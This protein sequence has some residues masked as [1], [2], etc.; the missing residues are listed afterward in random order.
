MNSQSH[1]L[2]ARRAAHNS[3]KR[4]KEDSFNSRKENVN[5]QIQTRTLKPAHVEKPLKQLLAH[6]ESFAH[7]RRPSLKAK[8]KP[9]HSHK[10]V[11]TELNSN[12]EKQAVT[13]AVPGEKGT[14]I[15]R[16]SA[17]AFRDYGE[18]IE[19]Y[20][21]SLESACHT[22]E[23]LN[24]HE[25]TA[26]LR[27]KMVD[28]MIEV[29]TNFKCNDQAFFMAVSLMDRYL[30]SKGERKLI[31]ELHVIGVTAM[32]LASKYEDILPLRME[33]MVK[34]IAHSKLSG[35]TIRKYEH[36]MLSTLNYFLQVPTVLEFMTRYIRGLEKQFRREKE[37]IQKMSLYL[38]KL[39]AHDYDFCGLAASK[40]AISSIYVALKI[41]EQLLKRE[42]TSREIV[43]QMA[44]VSGY[45]EEE[46]T[47]CAQKI[48]LDA[49][50]FDSL[51]PGLINLKRTHF[52]KL[53]EYIPKCTYLSS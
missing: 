27:A 33:I 21:K 34:K 24:R 12:G 5:L 9:E 52:T 11:L 43:Q 32:F 13:K 8:P 48:L 28:W 38:L 39:S 18:E 16:Q 41:G 3:F 35:E 31:C 45:S 20:E 6:N 37:L 10:G 17:N 36:D 30:K 50:N 23:C 44:E 22:H 14:D 19:E 26:G 51:F 40:M 2:A 47:E 42:I 1:R 4:I 53:M 29:M 49:Q 25:I 7:K 15:E 46:I